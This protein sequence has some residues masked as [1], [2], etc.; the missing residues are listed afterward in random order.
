MS[1]RINNVLH[2]VIPPNGCHSTLAPD[3]FKDPIVRHGNGKP[4][5]AEWM[6]RMSTSCQYDMRPFD[7]RCAG[8]KH[9]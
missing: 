9:P 7:E 2:D 1:I 6:H 5:N 8:C 3:R 4:G